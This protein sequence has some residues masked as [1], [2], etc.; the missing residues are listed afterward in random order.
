MY[1][2]CHSL[3]KSQNNDQDASVPLHDLALEP[4]GPRHRVYPPAKQC[5]PVGN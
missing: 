1:I 2:K 5:L 3:L 4:Q